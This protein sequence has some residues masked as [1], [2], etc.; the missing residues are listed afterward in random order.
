MC[1]QCASAE[2]DKSVGGSESFVVIDCWAC[3]GGAAH[4][5]VLSLTLSLS[6]IKINQKIGMTKQVAR[7]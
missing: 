4:K 5:C 3:I 2:Q 7:L 1:V 6:L